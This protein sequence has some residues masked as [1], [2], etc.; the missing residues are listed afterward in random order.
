MQCWRVVNYGDWLN[1][2]RKEN[3]VDW[4]YKIREA[5][6]AYEEMNR[7]GSCY[8]VVYCEMTYMCWLDANK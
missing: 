3:N 4:L 1:K 6:R 8:V 5:V 7:Y 2:N